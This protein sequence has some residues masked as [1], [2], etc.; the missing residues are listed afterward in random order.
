MTLGEAR[1][2]QIRYQKHKRQRKKVDK[3][4]YINV[5]NFYPANNTNR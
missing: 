1:M 3:L 5:A 4:D 2:S